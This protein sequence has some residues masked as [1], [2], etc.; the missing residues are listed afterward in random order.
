MNQE[1][2]GHPVGARRVSI[3]V[4]VLNEEAGIRSSLDNLA[5]FRREGAE[6]VI[7]DGGSTDDTLARAAGQCDQLISAPRGRGGQMNA[8]AKVASGDLLIFLHADTTLPDVALDVV[9]RAV[10]LGAV[11]GRFDV[12]IDGD[13]RWFPLIAYL[14]NLRSRVTGISTGD[15]AIF[16]TRTAFL[17]A[18]G[19]LDIPLMEDVAFSTTMRSRAR[20]TCVR[21]KVVTSGRRWECRGV[22]RTVLTMW[23]LRLR[24]YCG[25]SPA[26]LATDYGY[27]PR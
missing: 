27:R 1:S 6:L 9:R 21:E 5:P 25:A 14:I 17:D 24:F 19:F 22:V 2:M 12:C 3:V 16:V 10:D 7:V 8:G 4:P 23:W 26:K 11:W 18:G 13:S 15:Q 20:P